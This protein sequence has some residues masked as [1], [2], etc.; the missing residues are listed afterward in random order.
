MFFVFC[1]F[2]FLS[3]HI[4][5]ALKNKSYY[6]DDAPSKL[7]LTSGPPDFMWCLRSQRWCPR[8]FIPASPSSSA[9]TLYQ[10]WRSEGSRTQSSCSWK[11]ERCRGTL[12]W[13]QCP[14]PSL[15]PYVPSAGLYGFTSF[16]KLPC[17]A[18]LCLPREIDGLTYWQTWE[19]KL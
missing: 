4:Q 10:P 5:S 13:L 16:W 8:S 14:F 1:F 3:P 9:L 11:S 12:R 15:V 17:L 6:G 2:F 7:Y 19:E 18:A